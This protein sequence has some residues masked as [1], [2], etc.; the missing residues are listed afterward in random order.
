M[1]LPAG[2]I[3]T[4]PDGLAALAVVLLGSGEDGST[5]S[6]VSATKIITGYIILLKRYFQNVCWYRLYLHTSTF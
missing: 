2:K 4:P 5:E 6:G 1:A 3:R